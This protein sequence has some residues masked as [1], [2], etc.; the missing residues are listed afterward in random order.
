MLLV[1]K[2]LPVLLFGIILGLVILNITPPDSLTSASPWQI[3]IFFLPLF[4][5]L[6]FLINILFGFLLRSLIISLGILLLLVLKSLDSLNLVSV[7]ITLIAV[8]LLIKSLRNSSSSQS[9][10]PNLSHLSKQKHLTKQ[11]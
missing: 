11:R 9:K 1:K 4:L 7:L 2:L 6:T 3:I 8:G 10:I 5:F